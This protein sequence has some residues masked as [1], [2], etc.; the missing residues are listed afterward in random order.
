MTS[1]GENEYQLVTQG[2][3]FFFVPA[4]VRQVTDHVLQPLRAVDS[5]VYAVIRAGLQWN[6]TELTN[7]AQGQG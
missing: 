1:K 5:F 4:D 3:F 7:F 2:S 6:K